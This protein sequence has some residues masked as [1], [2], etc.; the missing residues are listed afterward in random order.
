[1]YRVNLIYEQVDENVGIVLISDKIKNFYYKWI[2]WI[3]V[4][5]NTDDFEPIHL[6]IH[7]FFI[8]FGQLF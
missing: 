2:L 8:K 5:K 6:F 1:M 3:H 4:Y 7:V